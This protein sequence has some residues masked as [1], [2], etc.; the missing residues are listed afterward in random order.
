MSWGIS[1]ALLATMGMC[2]VEGIGGTN[3]HGLNAAGARQIDIHR[4]DAR[5]VT[6][7]RDFM[8]TVG[9]GRAFWKADREGFQFC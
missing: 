5:M 2:I 8:E 7:K 6:A 4:Y 9:S 1:L 3:F